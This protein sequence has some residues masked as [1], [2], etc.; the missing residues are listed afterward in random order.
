M[1]SAFNG[2]FVTMICI[3]A[4]FLFWAF[5]ALVGLLPHTSPA[6][7]VFPWKWLRVQ[8]APGCPDQCRQNS[9]PIF[10]IFP[11]KWLRG[12]GRPRMSRP[13]PAK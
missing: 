1:R 5:L 9:L 4:V 12:A 10:V 6:S 8:A 7:C 3:L 13:M 11:W 2:F